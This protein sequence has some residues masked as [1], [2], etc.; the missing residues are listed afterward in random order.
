MSELDEFIKRGGK[1]QKLETIQVKRS[2]DSRYKEHHLH[3]NEG[4]AERLEQ[5]KSKSGK[6]IPRHTQMYLKFRKRFGL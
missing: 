5:Y 4:Q 1:I 3:A 6:Q 2:Y